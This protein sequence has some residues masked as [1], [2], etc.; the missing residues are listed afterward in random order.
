[1]PDHDIIAIEL[2]GGRYDGHR[3]RIKDTVR[4][5]CQPLGEPAPYAPCSAPIRRPRF[6]A[7]DR[8]D[9]ITVD[10]LVIYRFVTGR[11]ERR[12][13]TMAR[14]Y[15]ENLKIGSFWEKAVDLIP[16][17]AHYILT[18]T[19]FGKADRIGVAFYWRDGGYPVSVV[20]SLDDRQPIWEVLAPHHVLDPGS[21]AGARRRAEDFAEKLHALAEEILGAIG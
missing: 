12:R 2:V 10:G 18:S 19:L 9:E 13:G 20:M 5:E 8:T 21:P 17:E 4:L 16:E 7:Y 3:L 15:A 6:I 14:T 1:M 11:E